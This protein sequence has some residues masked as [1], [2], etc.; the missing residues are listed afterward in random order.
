MNGPSTNRFNLANNIVAWNSR[1]FEKIW[2]DFDIRP[3]PGTAAADSPAVVITNSIS[4]GKVVTQTNRISA[5][6]YNNPAFNNMEVDPAFVDTL[7]DNF[8]LKSSSPARDAGVVQPFGFKFGFV[9]SAPDMGAMEYGEQ[10]ATSV[11][12]YLVEGVA[13]TYSLGQN[14]PNP[15][16]PST[17]IQY[18]VPKAGTVTLN[19][20]NVIGQLVS[21]LV[22]QVQTAGTY[23]VQFDA[24]RLASGVYFYNLSAGS[25]NSTKKMVIMK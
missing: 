3:K 8:E 11:E 21:T 18:S 5:A 9:G 22:N 6:P 14:Y 10:T 15:F 24:S 17:T 19:V 12:P 13:E 25:F 2:Q 1:H 4:F 7:V 20:Y 16:N 23:N